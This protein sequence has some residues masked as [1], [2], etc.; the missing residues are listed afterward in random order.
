M[1][2]TLDSSVREIVT[3]D[4]R[5]AAVFER[6]GIDFCCGGGRTLGEA[7][8]ERDVDPLDVLL[9][10]NAVCHR[11]DRETPR[12]ADWGADALIAYILRTHHAYL[13]RIL[14]SLVSFTRTLANSHGRTR[15][16]LEE[17]ATVFASLAT[18]LTAHIDKEEQIVFPYIDALAMAAVLGEPAPVPPTRL[19]DG[20]IEAM[21]H[22]HEWAGDA[23]ARIRGLS[24]G[25]SV[26]D[27]ACPTYRACFGELE[28]F[29]HDL[30]VHVHLENNLLFPKARALAASAAG[31][32]A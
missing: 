10:V 21:E 32:P 25:Y 22:E 28:A 24:D 12:F 3:E 20:P 26:P 13:R 2:A 9:E 17:I 11:K 7:C 1:T 5:A 16:E 31:R 29:E 15:P 6:L 27:N 4:F 23:M 14:P 19:A 30:H 18:E 8:R